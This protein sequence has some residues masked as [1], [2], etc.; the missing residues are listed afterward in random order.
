MIAFAA[1]WVLVG[2][3]AAS[4]PI[5]LHL[6]ARREPPTVDF[7]AVRYLSE[8]ARTH[9]RRLTVQHWLLLLLRTALIMVLVLAAAGPSISSPRAGG[10]APSALVLVLDNSP[11]SGVT[12]GGVP[13]LDRLRMAAGRVLQRADGQDALW[14][15]TADGTIQRGTA[16][17]LQEV[18]RDLDVS[19]RRMDLGE[20]VT[21]ARAVLA[22][23]PLPGQVVLLTDLQH[24][25]LSQAVGEGSLVVGRPS[26]APA[27][28]TGIAAV[29]VGAQPWTAEGGTVA[30]TLVGDD[31]TGVPFSV[32]VAGRTLRQGIAAPGR[33]ATIALPVPGRGWLPVTVELAPDELRLDDRWT[34]AVRV[35]PPARADWD[36]TDRFVHLAMQV[37]RD[38]RRIEPGREVTMGWL[39]P[40]PSI[41]LPPADPSRVGA[42]NRALAARGVGWR[43]GPR[44]TDPVHTDSGP[45][46]DRVAVTL[47]HALEPMASGETGVLI[48]AGGAPW[49]VRSAGVVLVA[50]R[51]DPTWTALPHSSRFVPL[52]DALLNRMVRGEV[53]ALAAAA[54]EPV[55]V[56]DGIDAV[57]RDGVRAT[58]ES[59][60]PW[61]PPAPGR[62]F[63]LR[64]A[65]TVG[66][67]AVHLDPRESELTRA[68][69]RA[70][71]ELW[72][73]S[74]IVDLE[75][76]PA[77][78][79]AAAARTDLKGPLL[80][81][82]LLLGVAEAGLAAWRRRLSP[83]PPAALPA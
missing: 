78:A 70:V 66:V 68:S 61:R 76:V 8:T 57:V 31:T 77:L 41:V 64:D 58:A 79:F 73:G 23:E 52:L 25:A 47:R 6:F 67:V 51:F 32:S 81:L 40:G 42:L 27:P 2:L 44:V 46:L 48:R 29:E 39:G 50:S 17:E 33:P 56:P 35:A 10:H 37:L 16:A 26:G 80:W 15:L 45:L 1:P 71:R 13:L 12:Q 65:D 22:S 11:S 59:G 75:A 14:L 21:Q 19:H 7:P 38:G 18:V 3:V 36:S 9:Q 74:R 24:S 55:V 30:I 60:G 62:W 63:L 5:L 69:D 49:M 4:V 43:F 72:P 82:A 54:G 28:N 34:G 20:A 53:V 83:R